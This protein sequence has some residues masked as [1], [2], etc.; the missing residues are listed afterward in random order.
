M[1]HQAKEILQA[2]ASMSFGR[3]TICTSADV[4]FFP[5]GDRTWTGGT[6][7]RTYVGC[8]LKCCLA[9]EVETQGLLNRITT[10][11]PTP[12]TRRWMSSHPPTHKCTEIFPRLEFTFPGHPL[13]GREVA[14]CITSLLHTSTGSQKIGGNSHGESQ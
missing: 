6:Q 13:L 4:S 10:E 2:G 14:R 11:N 5:G 8:C 1:S 7:F 9:T 3:N 12:L